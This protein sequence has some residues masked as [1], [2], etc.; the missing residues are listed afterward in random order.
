M[1]FFLK[2][3]VAVVLL[4]IGCG[5]ALADSSSGAFTLQEAINYALDNNPDIA[6]MQARIEQA[7]AQLGEALAN[8][9]PQIKV[10]LAYQ[11]SDNPAQA[12]AMIIAQ[13]RLDFNGG[14]FN[15]PGGVDNYRP[16]VTA[17]YSLF[18][19]GQDYYA[20][21]AAELGVESSEL[22]KTATRHQLINNVTAAFYGY[23]AAKDA[24]ALSL[25]SIEAVQSELQ[26][27]RV[28][29]EAGTVLKSDVLSL[30]VQLAEAQDA[31]IRTANAIEIAQDMLRTLLGLSVVRNFSVAETFNLN[32]PET[33][34]E[35]DV[36]LKQAMAQ[37][38]GLMAADKHAAMAE[39]QLKAAKG[40]Y[41]PK[42]DAYV[43]YGSDSKNLAFSA[44]RDNVTAG[45]Q[46]EVDVFSGFATEERIKKAEHELTAA[47][48]TARKMRL[49]VE[50]QVKT[51]RLKLMEALNRERVTSVAVEAAEEALRLVNEQ[52]KAGVV[53][54]T[55]YIESEVA[56]DRAKTRDISARYDALRADAELKLATGFWN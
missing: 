53:T 39:Q 47:R 10:S 3:A 7:D 12:F 29:F 36:L 14:D 37:H 24:H 52:R 45:V 54:V 41:L 27:S 15:H 30:Q 23:L 55:R 17:T 40:A 33:P 22:E 49:Q 20:K 32:L 48:E 34:V 51:A 42:V 44:N 28:R 43:T 9:Y 6:I 13:R 21:Q 1:R 11:H 19:G 5:Q 50:N 31:E 8:F 4:F 46:M 56:R 16:Q 26:Q 2:K 35:F 18:R 25:R 38:P